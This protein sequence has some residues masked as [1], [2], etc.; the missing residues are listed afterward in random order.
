MTNATEDRLL[1][2]KAYRDRAAWGLCRGV[3]RVL[4]LSPARCRHI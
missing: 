4:G 3:L 2:T 1:A